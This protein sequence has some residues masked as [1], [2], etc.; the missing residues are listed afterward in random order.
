MTSNI[1]YPSASIKFNKDKK[2]FAFAV[3]IT[4][5]YTHLVVSTFSTDLD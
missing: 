5:V 4:Q 1:F 3:I 2:T